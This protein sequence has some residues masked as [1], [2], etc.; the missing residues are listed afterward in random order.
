M[1][2]RIIFRT[3]NASELSANRFPASRPPADRSFDLRAALFLDDTL[4]N[5]R[6]RK[7]SAA[8]RILLIVSTFCCAGCVSKYQY[9]VDRSLLMQENQKLED[10]LYVTHGQLVDAVRENDTLREQLNS[11]DSGTQSVRSP[12]FGAGRRPRSARNAAP[13]FG[14]DYAPPEVVIPE[15]NDGSSQPPD[16]IR[17]P[18]TPSSVLPPSTRTVRAP[19]MNTSSNGTL[20]TEPPLIGNDRPVAS[21]SI[22]EWNPRR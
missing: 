7:I 4:S 11:G 22:P 20:S 13:D 17:I 3:R 14:D 18:R 2:Y 10:A 1:N 19:S 5:R 12:A 8:F 21:P 15:G 16:G 9:E 6:L